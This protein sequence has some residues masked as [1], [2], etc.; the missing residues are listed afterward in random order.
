MSG[1][2]PLIKIECTFS[3][4]LG[5]QQLKSMTLAFMAINRKTDRVLLAQ[6]SQSTL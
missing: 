5:R 6:S 2:F 3:H 1:H 4:S